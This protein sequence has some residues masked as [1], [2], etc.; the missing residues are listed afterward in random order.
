MSGAAPPPLQCLS[1]KKGKSCAM[2]RIKNQETLVQSWVCQEP[3][4]QPGVSRWTNLGLKVSN[5]KIDGRARWMFS[6][7]ILKSSSLLRR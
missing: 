4:M 2:E 5:V 1:R 7:W 6:T 3:P